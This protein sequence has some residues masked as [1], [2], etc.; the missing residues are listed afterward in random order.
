MPQ[1]TPQQQEID[2]RRRTQRALAIALAVAEHE[3]ARRKGRAFTVG[4]FV[5]VQKLVQVYSIAH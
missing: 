3:E 2:Q 5:P 4:T 1:L